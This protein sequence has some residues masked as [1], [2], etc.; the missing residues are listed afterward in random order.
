[1]KGENAVARSRLPKLR[2]GVKQKTS[3]ELAITPILIKEITGKANLSLIT[4]L[5]LRFNDDRLPKIKHISGLNSLTSLRR[6][7]MSF[8]LIEKIENLSP[9]KSLSDLNLSE[10]CIEIL[11]N[12]VLFRSLMR[13]GRIGELAEA[14]CGRE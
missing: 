3:C 12:L 9:L 8:N 7:D 1:M 6:L 4:V 10:N 5:S 13:V 2:R 14:E 11:E